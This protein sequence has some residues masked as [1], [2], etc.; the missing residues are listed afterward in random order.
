LP[1]LKNE[2]IQEKRRELEEYK[3]YRRMKQ[4][5]RE[6]KRQLKARERHSRRLEVNKLSS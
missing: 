2:L 1:P 5:M 4:R 6:E 3:E